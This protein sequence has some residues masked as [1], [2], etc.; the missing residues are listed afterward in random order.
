[1]NKLLKI[2]QIVSLTLGV[3]TSLMLLAGYIY[4]LGYVHAFGLDTNLISKPISEMLVESWYLAVIL[5]GYILE[6]WFY[7]FIVAIALFLVMLMALTIAIKLKKEDESVVVDEI[8][9]D[10][11]GDRVLWFT[12]WHLKMLAKI[13]DQLIKNIILLP[14]FIILIPAV[15]TVSPY[16]KGKTDAEKQIS[17]QQKY[18]CSIDEKGS[19]QSKCSY[20]IDI[21][22]LDEKIISAGIIV[23][24]TEKKIAIF[25]DNLIEVYPLLDSYKIVKPYDKPIAKVK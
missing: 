16:Q 21:S 12:Q 15:I 10:N 11:Q 6:R 2:L 5:L 23:D 3:F 13:A 14:L 8:T 24:A 20:L 17:E 18:G 19:Y 1:L 7:F 22:Y 9:Q 4:H 25:H